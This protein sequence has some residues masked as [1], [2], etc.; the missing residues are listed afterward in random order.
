MLNLVALKG[1][2]EVSY[3][4]MNVVELDNNTCVCLQ[5]NRICPESVRRLLPIR[6]SISPYTL[7]SIYTKIRLLKDGFTISAFS[8]CPASLAYFDAPVYSNFV[9]Q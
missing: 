1:L 9:T 6:D 2:P 4:N 5:S 8:P 7:A 3:L